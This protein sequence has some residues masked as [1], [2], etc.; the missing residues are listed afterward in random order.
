MAEYVRGE[1][2]SVP[3]YLNAAWLTDRDANAAYD[4]A[5]EDSHAKVIQQ[6]NV[7]IPKGKPVQQSVA[8]QQSPKNEI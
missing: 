6:D 4:T 1:E 2:K 5:I 3:W 8:P 7:T